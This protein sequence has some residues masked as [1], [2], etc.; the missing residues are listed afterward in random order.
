[1]EYCSIEDAWGKDFNTQSRILPS[2][3]SSE[4]GAN[5]EIE[6]DS[7]SGIDMRMN[8]DYLDSYCHSIVNHVQGCKHCQRKLREI[9]SLKG[10]FKPTESENND[11]P[12]SVLSRKNDNLAYIPFGLDPEV[13]NV[14]LFSLLIIMFLFLMDKHK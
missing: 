1:M 5:A 3:S 6:N 8:N 4:W 7:H 11:L 2:R 12:Q 13:F 14:L 10:S 9:L